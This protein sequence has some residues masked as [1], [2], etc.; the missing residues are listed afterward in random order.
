[1]TTAKMDDNILHLFQHRPQII[2]GDIIVTRKMDRTL[3]SAEQNNK[4]TF[5]I[6][7]F[8]ERHM[9]NPAVWQHQCPNRCQTTRLA[10]LDNCAPLA[11]TSLQPHA[12][13]NGKLQIPCFSSSSLL[14][15]M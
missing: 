8:H 15:V 6:R 7:I 1:M 4:F 5:S 3:D 2:L 9:Q 12:L 10:H 14:K 11:V 13:F